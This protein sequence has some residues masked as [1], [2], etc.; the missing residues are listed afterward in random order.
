MGAVT[1]GVVLVILLIA[2]IWIFQRR[3]IEPSFGDV[4]DPVASGSRRP[5]P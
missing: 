2:A 5:N 1:T 4:P 3:L